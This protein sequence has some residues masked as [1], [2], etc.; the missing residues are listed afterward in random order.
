[1]LEDGTSSTKAN[2]V[3]KNGEEVL[4]HCEKHSRDSVVLEGLCKLF[5]SLSR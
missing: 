5:F 2:S 4:A 3:D 1:M